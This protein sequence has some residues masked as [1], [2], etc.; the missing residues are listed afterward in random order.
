MIT[1][2]DALRACP[3]LIYI[4]PLALHATL[5]IGRLVLHATFILVVGASCP[6]Y[7]LGGWRFMPTFIYRA[8]AAS[9][10]FYISRGWRFI[11]LSYIA[12]LPLH[13]AFIYRAVGASY[14]DS[15][16]C[17]GGPPW[18]PD[19]TQPRCPSDRVATEGHPYSCD[20]A[21]KIAQAGLAGYFRSKQTQLAVVP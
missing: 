10:Y 21:I 14:H 20:C 13:P 18:P 16:N 7:I 6:L 9:S 19:R 2:G 5:Y 3:G 15:R 1:Q 17:R 11:P 4:A 8:V 12:R